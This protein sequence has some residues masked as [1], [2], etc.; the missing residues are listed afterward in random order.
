[1]REA[2]AQRDSYAFRALARVVPCGIS[3]P[4]CWVA[5]KEDGSLRRAGGRAA[6][7]ETLCQRSAP[8]RT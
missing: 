5:V 7:L 3:L 2:G 8:T 1:M 6:H 4:T